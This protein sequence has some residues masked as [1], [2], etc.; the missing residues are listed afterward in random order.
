MIVDTA[1]LRNPH[2]H[3]TGDQP[4]TLD[5]GFLADVVRAVAGAVSELEA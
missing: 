2:Y 3:G 5:Y 4:G 1:N